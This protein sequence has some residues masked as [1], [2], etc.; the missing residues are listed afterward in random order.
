MLAQSF[1]KQQR[2]TL[3]SRNSR[4]INTN[5]ELYNPDDFAKSTNKLKSIGSGPQRFTTI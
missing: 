5:G 4:T 3:I 1:P 2:N